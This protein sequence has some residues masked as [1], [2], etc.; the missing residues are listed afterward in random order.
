MKLAWNVITGI[1][2]GIQQYDC[3]GITVP[4]DDENN[5]FVECLEGP[6][7][8]ITFLCFSLMVVFV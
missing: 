1:S 6:A 7:I 3:A 8:E 4:C 2:F 5:E